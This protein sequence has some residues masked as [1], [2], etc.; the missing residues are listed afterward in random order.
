MPPLRP[1][2]RSA[3]TSPPAPAR[4]VLALVLVHILSSVPVHVMGMTA[5]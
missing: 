3:T 5:P 1:L 4:R 2:A